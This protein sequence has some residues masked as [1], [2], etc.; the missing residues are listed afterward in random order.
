MKQK[1]KLTTRPGPWLSSQLQ[2]YLFIGLSVYIIEVLVIVVTQHLGGSAIIAVGLSFW[3][4]LVASF[5]LQK[6]ITFKDRRSHHS[7]LVPQAV[8][9]TL[10]VLFNFGFTI[11]VTNL[12]TPELPAVFIRTIALGIT[13]IWNFYLY[14]THIFKT[15]SGP[16]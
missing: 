7:V 2:R 13:T 5:T 8:A 9:Y 12:L 16:L 1:L 3:V 6:L 14:K 4:G 11:L 15:D 10:L